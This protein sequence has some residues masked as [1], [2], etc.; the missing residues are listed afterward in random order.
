VIQPEG[1]PHAFAWWA[2][3]ATHNQF[4]ASVGYAIVHS[5][6]LVVDPLSDEP[7]V[8]TGSH[9]FSKAAS[10]KN[11]ENFVVV[12][13]DRALAEAYVVNVFSAW[14]HYRARVA[15]GVPW[16]GLKKDSSWMAGSL[17]ARHAEAD[18]WGF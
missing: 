2:A 18:F 13:G 10:D 1:R 5:K 12:R 6:V 3:E 15:E 8:V 7:V 9:N 14:R 11:D 17:R 4:K 16:A